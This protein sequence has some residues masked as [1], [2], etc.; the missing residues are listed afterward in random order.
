VRLYYYTKPAWLRS[1]VL[2]RSNFRVG[3][4]GTIYS[5]LALFQRRLPLRGESELV[6]HNAGRSSRNA[7]R[8]RIEI[9]FS[10]DDLRWLADTVL[11][12]ETGS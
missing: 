10:N 12:I 7:R 8:R 1:C 6:Q 3:E 2:H 4:P 5:E 11:G 9:G